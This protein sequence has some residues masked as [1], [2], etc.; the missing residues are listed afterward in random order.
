[1][2]PK[3][4]W[5]CYAMVL[6]KWHKLGPELRRSEGKRWDYLVD[7]LSGESSDNSQE[8]SQEE[9]TNVVYS[10][11]SYDDSNK[12]T[13]W[14]NGT[15]QLTGV[16]DEGYTQVEVL[17]NSSDQSFVGQKFYI[18]SDAEADGTTVYQLYSDAGTTPAGIYVTIS[19]YEG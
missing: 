17:T 13:E 7:E 1:M 9:D 18:A 4:K 3:S 5:M 19:N 8:N 15:V 14:G 2:K 6:K 12:T 16:T 10:F 11:V